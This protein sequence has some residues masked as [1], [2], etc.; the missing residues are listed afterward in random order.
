V[1]RSGAAR[2][3]PALATDYLFLPL[4]DGRWWLAMVGGE[5]WRAAMSD[6]GGR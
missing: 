4:G 2:R 5:R 1:T 6:D 3:L